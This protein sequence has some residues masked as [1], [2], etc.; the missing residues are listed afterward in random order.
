LYVT[1]FFGNLLFSSDMFPMIFSFFNK[2]KTQYKILRF[3]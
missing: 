1:S 2:I 3:T